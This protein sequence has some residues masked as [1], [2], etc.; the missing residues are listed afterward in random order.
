MFVTYKNYC[1]FAP[2]LRAKRKNGIEG[3]ERKQEYKF[4][5]ILDWQHFQ[6]QCWKKN[7]SKK[8]NT[9]GLKFR[10][11]DSDLFAVQY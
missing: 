4:I 1:T 2:A 10:V 6:Q 11:K 5:D 9:L 3:A 8:E 7:E